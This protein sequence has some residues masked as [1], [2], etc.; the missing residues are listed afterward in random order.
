MCSTFGIDQLS[1]DA[2]A[3]ACF[4]D[5]ALQYIANAEF[6]SYLLDV[7]SLSLIRK[8]RITCDHEQPF[9]SRKSSRDILHHAVG[10]VFLLWIA[11][12]VLE[13]K[14]SDGRLVGEGEGGGRRFDGHGTVRANNSEY[15]DRP[16][17]ILQG[18]LAF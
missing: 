6:P 10:E 1:G 7:D 15:L 13:R 2:N 3:V 4:P 5:T 11:T 17:Y 14:H 12:H 16:G 18:D 9:D 8:T